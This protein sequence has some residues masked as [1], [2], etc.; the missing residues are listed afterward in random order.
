MV[1]I[2][3][4]CGTKKKEGFIGCDRFA[5]DNVD[6]VVDLGQQ[7]WPFEDA[8]V[9]E[10]YSCHFVEHLTQLERIHF[11]NELHRVLKDGAKATIIVPSWSSC[12]AYGDMTHQWPPVSPFWFYYLSKDWRKDNAPHNDIKHWDKGYS[13]DFEVTWG[14]GIHPTVASRNAEFQQFATQFYIEAVQDIHATLNKK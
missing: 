6:H 2:D 1:K 3:L 7:R 5:F 12:R 14:L 8:S 13:C 11:V 4:G 9:D 10:A